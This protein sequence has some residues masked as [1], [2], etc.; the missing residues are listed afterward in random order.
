[1]R[2]HCI[3]CFA[4]FIDGFIFYLLVKAQSLNLFVLLVISFYE[5]MPGYAVDFVLSPFLDEENLEW[6]AFVHYY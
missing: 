1:M 4:I 2:I 5:V 6:I 3:F